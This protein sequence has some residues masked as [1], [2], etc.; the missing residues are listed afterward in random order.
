MFSA[1]L[2]SA[3][4]FGQ[5]IDKMAYSPFDCMDTCLGSLHGLSDQIRGRRGEEGREEEGKDGRRG[6]EAGRRKRGAGRQTKHIQT[7]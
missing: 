1:S 2:V 6:E 7:H 4:P 3:G 5:H